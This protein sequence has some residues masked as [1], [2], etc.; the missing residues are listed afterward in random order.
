MYAQP[1]FILMT[2]I[3]QVDT[4]NDASSPHLYKHIMYLPIYNTQSVLCMGVL[5][6]TFIT[7]QKGDHNCTDC[8]LPWQMIIK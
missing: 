2:I 3:I 1:H 4:T 8:Q 7:L 6:N 5:V